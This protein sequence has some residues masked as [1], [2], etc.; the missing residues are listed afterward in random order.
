[1]HGEI[2]LRDLAFVDVRRIVDGLEP[3]DLLYELGFVER[4]LDD[5][6]LQVY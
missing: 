6:L 2:I 1:M 3:V 5:D 4:A